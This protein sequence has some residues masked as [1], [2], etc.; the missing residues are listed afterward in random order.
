M[1][2]IVPWCSINFVQINY[3]N[4]YLSK[5][6][7]SKPGSN[8]NCHN[9][10]GPLTMTER[11]KK[12]LLIILSTYSQGHR[13]CSSR[14]LLP[15]TVTVT[16]AHICGKLREELCE[17]KN[18]Y[19]PG[20]SLLLKL[21]V[22]NLK[23]GCMFPSKV[24]KYHLQM[25]MYIHSVGVSEFVKVGITAGTNCLQSKTVLLYFALR[26]IFRGVQGYGRAV[27]CKFRF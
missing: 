4:R 25:V 23:F 22:Q 27:D 2:C 7:Y 18:P 19:C 11:R 10:S 21:P 8:L 17:V 12:T 20:P 16:V 14:P 15:V 26:W 6:L 3:A 24:Q 1:P 13:H 5:L 9:M